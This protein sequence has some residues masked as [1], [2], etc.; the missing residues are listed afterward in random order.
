MGGINS[1]GRGDGNVYEV[2]KKKHITKDDVAKIKD[3]LKELNLENLVKVKNY[4]GK[5]KPIIVELPN[6]ADIQLVY[7]YFPGPKG[8]DPG[9]KLVY[10]YFPQDRGKEEIQPVYGYFPRKPMHLKPPEEELPSK[11]VYGYFPENKLEPDT[12]F[13]KLVYGYFPSNIEMK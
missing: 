8:K 6:D 11:L 10:G 7:G 13:L 4:R 1:I 12:N 3:E 5:E 9:I 2:N